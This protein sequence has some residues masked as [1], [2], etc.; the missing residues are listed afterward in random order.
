MKEENECAYFS[1]R[2]LEAGVLM[3]V[4]GRF[5]RWSCVAHYMLPAGRSVR[6]LGHYY[7]FSL[8]SGGLY[9]DDYHDSRRAWIKFRR[10]SEEEEPRRGS[11][12]CCKYMKV[13]SWRLVPNSAKKACPRRRN[14]YSPHLK[15][16]LIVTIS[17]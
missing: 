5:K 11:A 12:I 17:I 3:N 10:G 9:K 15:V 14:Q 4:Y 8:G 6:L 1:I 7:F 2:V 13:A 16:L